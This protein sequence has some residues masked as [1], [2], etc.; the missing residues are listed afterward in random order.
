MKNAKGIIVTTAIILG[1]MRVWLQLHGQTT[2]TFRQ[3]VIGFGALMFG[4]AVLSEWSAAA[5][6]GFALLI[7]VTDLIENGK[8][9][10]DS[11]TSAIKT[12]PGNTSSTVVPPAGSP[13]PAQAGVTRVAASPV[14]QGF[15]GKVA[16]GG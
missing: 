1:G 3:W 14:A 16:S 7:V 8:P 15:A 12:A 13:Q 9:L 11:I 5:A 2:S 6:G 10:F 4:L